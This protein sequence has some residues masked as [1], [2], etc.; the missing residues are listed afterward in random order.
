MDY[1]VASRKG[2]EEVVLIM[3]FSIFR[4]PIL[5]SFQHMIIVANPYPLCV[6]GQ[7]RME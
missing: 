1:Y 3:S 7:S 4:I 2:V 5:T 6:S